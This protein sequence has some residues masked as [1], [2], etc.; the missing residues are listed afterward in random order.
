MRTLKYIARAAQLAVTLALALLLAGNLYL[1]AARALTGV[2]QPTLL[3][4]SVAS[5]VSG[6]MEPALSVHDL[7]VTR[8]QEGYAVGDVITF[9]SDGVLVTHRIVGREA[10]DFRT[11]G[12]ANNAED[13]QPVPLEDVVGKVVLRIPL[14]GALPG[15]LRTP[16]GVMG[17]ALLGVLLVA[18][19]FIKTRGA[20]P[21]KED[22]HGA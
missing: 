7:I 6:S 4:F 14:L 2:R 10:N 16:Q 12:D 8:A 11:Q 9:Y 1:L 21:P 20:E 18:P 15:F 22:E 19:L 17:L 5:V 13:V 3:G